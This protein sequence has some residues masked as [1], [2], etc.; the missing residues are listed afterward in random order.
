[1]VHEKIINVLHILI[2]YIIQKINILRNPHSLTESC[3]FILDF[4]FL[5]TRQIIKKRGI[6]NVKRTSQDSLMCT[7]GYSVH[8]NPL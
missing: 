2:Q 8:V 6:C 5:H 3:A 1:M 7:V 4:F